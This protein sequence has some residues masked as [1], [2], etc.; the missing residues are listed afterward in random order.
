M[1]YMS[2]PGV[3]AETVQSGCPSGSRTLTVMEYGSFWPAVVAIEATA[4]PTAATGAASIS[5][6]VSACT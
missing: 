3:P 2:N 1:K 6:Q 4:S 5:R